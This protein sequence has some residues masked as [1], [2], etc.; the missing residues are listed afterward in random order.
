MQDSMLEA[1]RLT[2]DGKLKEATALIQRTLAAHSSPVSTT[3][4]ANM[5]AITP[6]KANQ[7][8][9]A[10][11]RVLDDSPAPHKSKQGQFIEKSYSNPAGTRPY[12]LYIPSGYT[13]QAV[14]LVVML[15][16]CS[17]N[18]TNF[19]IG[20]RMNTL[21]EEATFLVAY[22]EQGSAANS[23]KCWNWY[24]KANQQRDKGEPSLIAGITEQVMRDYQIDTRRI[25][26]A[27][28]SS[29]GAMA[30][31]M[32]ATYPHLY[33]A[34]CV[35]SGL[36]YSAAHDLPS[37]FAA[38]NQGASQPAKQLTKA[39]P[40]IIFHGDRDTT[41]AP[42]NAD[43]LLNQW[44]QATSRTQGAALAATVER[45]HAKNGYAYTRSLYRNRREQVLIEQW[46]VHQAGH[47]WFGGNPQGSYTDMR[48]PDASSEMLRFFN[49]HP[50]EQ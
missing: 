26:I 19:S 16:G 18:A 35:H 8:I 40:L 41:V 17:Q 44:L 30:A 47:A 37:A 45:A 28:L 13:G 43:T 49:Q 24:Q 4:T 6:S 1:A 14:P 21:A 46:L 42:S 48:G 38:M 22:P 10:E 5:P 39:I 20:T 15:H 29:G 2:R 25:Y 23:T 34:V 32:A 31:I 3:N 11:F 12:K 50:K 33:A 36:A 9:E 7:P 27:G